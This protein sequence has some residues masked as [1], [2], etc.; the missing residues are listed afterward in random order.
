MN[1]LDAIEFNENVFETVLNNVSVAL[2][3]LMLN[4]DESDE[5]LCNVT[6]VLGEMMLNKN[7][8]ITD[9]GENV[10]AL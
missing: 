2:G 10:L 1:I 9:I 5:I 7:D 4:R 8:C 6:V 3:R